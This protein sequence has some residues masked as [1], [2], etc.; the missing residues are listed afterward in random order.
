ML[1][2][3]KKQ[4]CEEVGDEDVKEFDMDGE[5]EMRRRSRDGFVLYLIL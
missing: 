1:A 2:H 3:L 5:R 4:F